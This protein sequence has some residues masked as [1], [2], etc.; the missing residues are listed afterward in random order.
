M[1]ILLFSNSN[2]SFHSR[3]LLSCVVKVKSPLQRLDYGQLCNV[4]TLRLLC[5]L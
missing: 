5:G 1:D 2:L 4:E 3:C